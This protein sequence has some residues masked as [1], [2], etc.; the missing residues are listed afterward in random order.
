MS[1]AAEERLIAPVECVVEIDNAEITSLYPYIKSVEVKMSR[2]AATTCTIL[3]DSTRDETGEWL[4]QDQDYMVPWKKLKIEAHFG[5]YKEEVM[6]GYIRDVRVQHPQDMAAS[7]VTVT[8]QDDSILFDREH[9][10]KTWS[11][12]DE[13]KTDGEIATEIASDEGLQADTEDGLRN[14]SLLQ[15]ETSITF[16]KKRAEANGF[17][18]FFRQGNLHFYSP[19]LDEQPQDA[20][21]VY[22]GLSTNCLN[23]E[24]N[25]DGHKPDQINV[26][27]APDTGTD[28]EAE[29]LKPDLTLLGK[30]AADSQQMGLTKFQWNMNQPRGATRAEAEARTQAAVNKNAWKI[31]ATGELDGALYGHVLLSHKTVEV[32]GVGSTWGG[33]YYVDEV[34]HVFS[35]EGYRQNFKLLRNATGQQL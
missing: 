19:R 3:L 17:E 32:D 6:R 13:Q 31:Q 15:D 35:I 24:A 23:F 12:E 9:I 7:V 20:I 22:A 27:R 30:K 10:R 5:S 16:L 25:Y 26:V 8:G 28:P 29:V 2:S 18:L 21:M 11:R 14:N 34:T 4:V 1:E 33:K